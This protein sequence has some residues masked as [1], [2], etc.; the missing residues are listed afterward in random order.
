MKK[1]LAF[2][3]PFALIAGGLS[4]CNP[5]TPGT[6]SFS[7]SSPFGSGTD[8]TGDGTSPYPSADPSPVV[9]PDASADPNYGVNVMNFSISQPSGVNK[10]VDAA[11]FGMSTSS[12]DNSR[13]F[14]AA[15]AYLTAN[16]GTKLSIKKGV[17]HFDPSNRIFLGKITNCIIDG[18]GSE[19]LFANGNYFDLYGCDTL[20][21]QNLTIDWDWEEGGRLASLVRVKSVSGKK[22]V[23]EFFETDDASYAVTTPWETLNEF[24]PKSLTPGCE[25]GVEYWGLASGASNKTHL[26][27]NLVSADINAGD[28]SH[29]ASGQVYLL[30][31]YTY[32]SSVFYTGYYSKNITY[33]NIHIYSAYGSGFVA[34][35][36]ANHMLFSDITIGLRPGTENKYRISTTV[37]AFHIAD[38][39]GYFIMDNCDVSFQGDDC[40]NVH[41]NIGVVQSVSGNTVVVAC[42]STGNYNVG[43]QLTFKN[44]STY[45]AYDVRATVTD[46]TAGSGKVTLTLDQAMDNSLVGAVVSDDSRNS[47]HYIVRNCYFHECRARGL[48]LGSGNGL[49]ENNRF[50]K[51]QGAAILIP[52]DII[53]GSWME[54]TGVDNLMIRN[55]TFETCNVNNWTPLIQF[56]ANNNGKTINGECFTNIAIVNNTMIDFPSRLLLIHGVRNVT[57]AGNV[58]KNPTAMKGSLRGVIEAEYFKNLVI[59]DNTWYKSAYMGSDVNEVQLTER[60]PDKSQVTLKNNVLK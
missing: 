15:A 4:A 55:N 51:T 46:K 16:P 53:S 7:G 6:T 59:T 21:I 28:A 37:D 5:S 36:G 44:A 49:V 14:L 30:R 56:V 31:H 19:F 35:D 33:K 57:V 3:I 25:G 40:L 43:A 18:N 29:F 47:S 26:G 10:T 52:I 42:Q 58:I 24:D 22:V 38:T 45:V 32:R 41:D 34:G 12:S 27:G 48:L 8:G 17:Y 9:S 20:L 39:A 1:I 11:Q 13:A 2:L 60:N 23:F 54:G 50:F